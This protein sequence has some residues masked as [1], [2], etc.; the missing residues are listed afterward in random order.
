MKA[1]YISDESKKEEELARF[2]N[3][4]PDMKSKELRV[5]TQ[6]SRFIGFPYNNTHI[7]NIL[8]P[9]FDGSFEKILMGSTLRLYN[10][11]WG[12]AFLE[13]LNDSLTPDGTIIVPFFPDEKA[14]SRGYWSLAALKK[15]FSQSVQVFKKDF[16][17]EF[18]KEKSLLVKRQSILSW[19]FQDYAKLL[20]D[21]LTR[22]VSLVGTPKD[23]IFSYCSDMMLNFKCQGAGD[24]SV[25]VNDDSIRG[26]VLIDIPKAFKRQSYWLYGVNFKSAVMAHIIKKYFDRNHKLNLIDHGAGPGLLTGELLLNKELNIAKAVNSDICLINMVLA[27]RMF[28]HFRDELDG[29]FFFNLGKSEEYDYKDSYNIVIFIGSL[30]YVSKDKV[31]NTLVRAWEAI[32]PGGILVVQ[33]NIKMPSY[34]GK[35]PPK[36]YN[37]MF[38]VDELEDLLSRFGHIDYYMSTSTTSVP[39]EKVGEKSV[40]RV[41]KKLND[42]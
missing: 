1:I 14:E 22:S 10:N 38:T 42:E 18:K 26:Q 3:V 30:L 40:F 12:E 28:A 15:I 34:E 36:D 23:N 5:F 29:R 8:Y 37:V 33:E 4:A 39:K 2:A 17:V 6:T 21:D 13:K 25:V 24:E 20:I 19:Y 16:F 32:R 9:N 27:R 11:P 41:V 35:G 7:G 31:L